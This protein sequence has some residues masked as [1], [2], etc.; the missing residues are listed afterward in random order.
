M[1]SQNASLLVSHS[2]VALYYDS[3]FAAEHAEIHFSR[4]QADFRSRPHRSKLDESLVVHSSH[5]RLYDMRRGRRARTIEPLTILFAQSEFS[6][7]ACKRPAALRF[8]PINP[9]SRGIPPHSSKLLFNIFVSQQRQIALIVFQGQSCPPLANLNSAWAIKPN[10][11]EQAKWVV[12]GYPI[13][14]ADCVP[15]A[16]FIRKKSH[17]IRTNNPIVIPLKSDRHRQRQGNPLILRVVFER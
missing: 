1:D 12:R 15:R 13:P 5:P 17:K 6:L 11:T 9:C 8:L 16:L 4:G 10:C 7:A 14:K 3:R 2:I